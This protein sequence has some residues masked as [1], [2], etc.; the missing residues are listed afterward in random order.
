MG[1]GEHT[2]EELLNMYENKDYKAMAMHN[3]YINFAEISRIKQAIFEGRLW[4]FVEKRC[5]AH[6][7]LLSAVKNLKHHKKY[8]ERFESISKKSAF[9]YTGC[10]SINRPIVYRYEKRFFE[11]YQHPK[12]SVQI[13][14]EEGDRPYS[15]FYKKEI[16]DGK[17]KS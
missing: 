7:N 5:R 13:G 16:A 12:V 17:A 9:F 6:P 1:D 4:E 15:K 11:R 10:E 8:L 3:L 14:F 2:V